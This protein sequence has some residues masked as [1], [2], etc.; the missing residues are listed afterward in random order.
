MVTVEDK[1]NLAGPFNSWRKYSCWEKVSSTIC[2]LQA[3]RGGK[4]SQRDPFLFRRPAPEKL[5]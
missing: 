2:M 5:A 4:K 3:V 1:Q